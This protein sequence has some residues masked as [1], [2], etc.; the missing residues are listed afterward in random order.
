MNLEPIKI[1]LKEGALKPNEI[2]FLAKSHEDACICAKL[3]DLSP[4]NHTITW[5]PKEKISYEYINKWVLKQEHPIIIDL[6]KKMDYFEGY[7]SIYLD[8]E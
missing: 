5:N 7:Y 3:L 4:D 2:L 1:L 6:Y 8:K